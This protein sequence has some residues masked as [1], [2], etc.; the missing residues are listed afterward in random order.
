MYELQ[1]YAPVGGAFP[2]QFVPQQF[3][4]QSLFGDLL[5]RRFGNTNTYGCGPSG[6]LGGP[7]PLL[8]PF[9]VDP[10]AQA[11]LQLAQLAQIEQQQQC[12]PQGLTATSPYGQQLSPFDVNPV[13]A[14]LA[15]Q[16]AQALRAML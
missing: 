1:Q 15:Y 7:R 4:P 8:M 5:G 6:S 16:Q 3:V 13:A 10:V 14:A 12:A 11:Y 2:N 9:D